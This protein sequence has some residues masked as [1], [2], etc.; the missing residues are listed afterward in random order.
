MASRAAE[1][2][3]AQGHPVSEL[4]GKVGLVTGASSGL[5]I[6]FARILAERGCHLVLVARRED[7]LEEI[8]GELRG[9]NGVEVRTI[10]MDLSQK[11][12][13]RELYDRTRELGL[14]VEVL[15]NNAG[16]GIFGDF[17]DIPWE[18]EREMLEL[19]ILTL[20]Q[21]TKLFLKD[22]VARGHGY[23]LQ[24]ASIG[25]YQPSPS[26]ATY[27]AAKSFVLHFGEAIHYELRGTGV[28]V[29]VVS[30][31]V[32]ATEFLK[33]AGQKPNL[34]QRL[35]MMRSRAV[36]EM[37]IRAMLRGK[38][39]KVTG[40]MNFLSVLGLR[41]L[42]RRAMTATAGFLMKDERRA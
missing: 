22:M 20:V 34:Y 30:P 17:K 7:R 36:A 35:A 32:I 28:K 1:P 37:G 11:D 42:P 6:E 24:V 19:D 12:S 10:P 2:A 23:V 13:A 21:L 18:R 31:G 26:Y 29:S 39:S 16:F 15:V 8:A 14:Q 38:P 41:L 40:W 5:G 9:R 33:V 25:A 3:H 4:E 27:S